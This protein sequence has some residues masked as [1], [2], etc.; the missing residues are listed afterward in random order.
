MKWIWS[1]MITNSSNVTL[2]NR[3]GRVFQVS[4]RIL[5]IAE[6]RYFKQWLELIGADGDIIITF[7]GIVAGGQ[8]QRLPGEAIRIVLAMFHQVYPF[9]SG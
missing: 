6:F 7:C 5:R 3:V 8:S 9:L 4:F 2:G 1:G